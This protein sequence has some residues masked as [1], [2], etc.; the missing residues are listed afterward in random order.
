[1]I[2][3][4]TI[5]LA[6]LAFVSGCSRNGLTGPK[7]LGSSLVL[8]SHQLEEVNGRS[9][10]TG[11]VRNPTNRKLTTVMV[12]FSLYDQEGMQIGSTGAVVAGLEPERE[13]KFSAPVTVKGFKTYKLSQIDAF[14]KIE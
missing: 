6:T 10:I 14:D 2:K 9:H 13:W 1:M 5:L 4:F 12:T 7:N 11:V 8:V 3:T